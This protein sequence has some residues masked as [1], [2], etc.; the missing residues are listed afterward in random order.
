MSTVVCPKC[1]H[2]FEAV[3]RKRKKPVRKIPNKPRNISDEEWLPFIRDKQCTLKPCDQFPDDPCWLW[4]GNSDRTGYGLIW[5][6]RHR[7]TKRA[8]RV[9]YELVHGPLDEKPGFE[10]SHL[11]HRPSC[12]NP[13][14][15]RYTTHLENME[16][17]AERTARI[18]LETIQEVHRRL[19]EGERQRKIAEDL[20]LKERT[21]HNIKAGRSPRYRKK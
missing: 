1:N 16:D 13:N 21:V 3:Q 14:H 11:C 7:I 17:G 6:K 5:S 9:T 19:K 20:G 15:V 2:E 12:C 10:F 4:L 8:H 18:P